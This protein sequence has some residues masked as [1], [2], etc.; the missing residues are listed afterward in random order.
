MVAKK[1]PVKIEVEPE[2]EPNYAYAKIYNED[3]SYPTKAGKK[4][5]IL[6]FNARIG[7]LKNGIKV[8]LVEGKWQLVKL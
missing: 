8:I 4:Q 6:L 1:K 2:E 3:G 5:K 7:K